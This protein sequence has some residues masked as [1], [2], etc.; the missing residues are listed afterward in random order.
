MCIMMRIPNAYYEDFNMG[1]VF[2]SKASKKPT[3]LSVN[4]DLLSRARKMK[5]NL[6]ATLEK[7]LIIE[8]KKA[9]KEKWLKRNKKAID[10][11]NHLAEQ[12]GLF[13]DSFREF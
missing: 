11:L 3:N 2:D 5:I 9:E 12:K 1:H 6:S 7:A 10:A 13:S 4:S 8:I